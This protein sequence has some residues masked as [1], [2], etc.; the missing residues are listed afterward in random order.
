[1]S[2][3]SPTPVRAGAPPRAHLLA[4]ALLAVLS[5]WDGVAA[6]L[7]L[8]QGSADLAAA[9]DQPPWAVVVGKLVLSV[10]GLVAAVVVA[11]AQRWGVV[12]ALG[13]AVGNALLALPGVAF[14]PT[15]SS[16]TASAVAAV[17]MG[18]VVFLLLRRSGSR[19]AAR[20]PR[21]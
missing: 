11:R 12:L 13:V 4:A 2:L 21:G 8:P 6:V 14:G 7:L 20:D 18:L 15:T 3:T 10:L 16:R 1:M 5:V 9:G 17:G 19:A